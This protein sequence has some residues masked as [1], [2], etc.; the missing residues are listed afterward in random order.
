[1]TDLPQNLPAEAT[2][3]LARKQGMF[4][5]GELV[6]AEAG[7]TAAIQDPGR[8]VTLT[9]VP[10]GTA[11][12]VD[13]AVA[14]ARAAFETGPW[15]RMKPNERS[16]L[17]WRLRTE[18]EIHLHGMVPPRHDPRHLRTSV[19][20]GQSTFSWKRLAREDRARDALPR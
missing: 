10:K 5:N 9:E 1:M 3:W 20:S 6:Q 15:R 19:Y 13:R 8:D 14:A 12:D 16:K 2:A 18:L 11:T 7:E 4:I 17:I